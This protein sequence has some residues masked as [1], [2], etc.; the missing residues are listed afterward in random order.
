MASVNLILLEDVDSL[1]LAGDSV[2]VASGYARNFLIPKN[3]G[4]IASTAAL[5][6]VESRKV[7]IAEK[8]EKSILAAKEV[9]EKLSSVEVII[10]MEASD[11]DKLFGS[12]TERNI[13]DKLKEQ[14]FDFNPSKIKLEN[15]HIKMLGVSN[16]EVKLHNDV[17][18]TIKVWVVKNDE[19]ETPVEEAPVEETPVE[20]TPVEETLVEE[21]TNAEG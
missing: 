17:T 8:R 19:S 4:V 21:P 1:G 5:R 14:D 6:Q 15:G 9:A 13:A 20:E 11:D 16:V 18:A 7:I 10:A 2:S 3:K 12:V